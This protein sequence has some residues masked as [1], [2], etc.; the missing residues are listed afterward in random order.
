MVNRGIVDMLCQ[1]L[2]RRDSSTDLLIVAL[3]FLRKLSVYVENKNSMV[4][5][6]IP[7]AAQSPRFVQF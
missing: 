7:V 4:R 1:T 5:F 6:L 2:D 3:S